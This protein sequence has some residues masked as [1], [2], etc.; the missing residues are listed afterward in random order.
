MT[1][2]REA[3]RAAS[4]VLLSCVLLASGCGDS[5]K[6]P[7]A[8]PAAPDPEPDAPEPTETPQ[9]TAEDAGATG[10]DAGDKDELVKRALIKMDM[11]P[12]L[13]ADAQLGHCR[14]EQQRLL[15]NLAEAKKKDGRPPRIRASSVEVGGPPWRAKMVGP[16][17]CVGLPDQK[18][19]SPHWDFTLMLGA[20]INRRWGE[21]LR[22][23]M[24]GPLESDPKAE[25][26]FE[27]RMV[28][29]AEGKPIEVWAQRSEGVPA[30]IS[31]CWVKVVSE[32]ELIPK[33]TYMPF[34]GA[35]VPIVLLPAGEE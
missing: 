12:K 28:G 30:E 23:C 27:L 11:R 22:E 32:S 24:A 14:K 1:L 33:P 16:R 29:D 34:V 5:A 21:P 18:G 9:P 31:D 7:P 13:A 35:V 26:R 20:L 6:A 2:R 17:I 15:E 25:G 3:K 10:V 19:V 8:T 4:L